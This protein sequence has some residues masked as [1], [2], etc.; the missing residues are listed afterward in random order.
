MNG[1]IKS[2]TTEFEAKKLLR[3]KNTFKTERRMLR[4]YLKSYLILIKASQH[5]VINDLT[6]NKTLKYLIETNKEIQLIY[7]RLEVASK[8]K[9]RNTIEKT[10]FNDCEKSILKLSISYQSI[11]S[12]IEIKK[13]LLKYGKYSTTQVSNA[14]KTL[15]KSKLLKLKNKSCYDGKIRPKIYWKYHPISIKERL[16]I[17]LNI[18]L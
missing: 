16:N 4:L 12:E 13:S 14:L 11:F 8:I 3:N 6:L 10:S 17:L 15:V 9:H 2:L 5:D 7:L 1:Y 18:S